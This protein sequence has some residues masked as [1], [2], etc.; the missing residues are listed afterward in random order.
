MIKDTLELNKIPYKET[1]N[2]FKVLCPGHDDHSPSLVIFKNSGYCYCPVCDYKKKLCDYIV[3]V[4]DPTKNLSDCIAYTK[5]KIVKNTN[6]IS[7]RFCLKYP[8]GYQ[9]YEKE[10]PSLKL[11]MEAIKF[12]SIGFCAY[13]YKKMINDNDC[14]NCYFFDKHLENSRWINN[15]KCY[16]SFNRIMTPILHDNTLLSI[17]SRTLKKNKRKL[18]YPNGSRGHDT[19]FNYNNLDKNKPLYVVEGIKSAL[20]LW[21]YLDKNITAIFS[22]RIKNKQK[23]ILKNFNHIIIIPDHGVAGETLIKDFKELDVPEL[24][25]VYLPKIVLCKDCGHKFRGTEK[26]DV[27]PNCKSLETSFADAFDFDISSLKKII[28]NTCK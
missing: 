26:I 5:N 12:F 25:I 18:L 10:L 8:S 23:E 28:D 20:Y 7:K 11:S 6:P 27:C 2:S 19:I 4:K 1:N 14:K 17:E 9:I 24:Q 3:D 16:F 15:G 13:G 22:N 21:S